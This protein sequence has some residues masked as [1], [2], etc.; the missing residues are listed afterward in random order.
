MRNLKMINRYFL[1]SKD[2]IK[3]WFQKNLAPNPRMKQVTHILANNQ[4]NILNLDVSIFKFLVRR[5][6]HWKHSFT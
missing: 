3:D 5:W 4:V 2:N 1:E 6:L